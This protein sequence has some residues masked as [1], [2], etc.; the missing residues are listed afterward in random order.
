MRVR[1]ESLENIS[2]TS[3]GINY[4]EDKCV[5][6]GLTET[7]CLRPVHPIAESPRSRTNYTLVPWVA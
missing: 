6:N 5:S 4:S 1:G 3:S 7:N 2:P